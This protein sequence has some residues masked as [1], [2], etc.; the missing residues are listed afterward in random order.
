MT[1]A[2]NDDD[3]D[4]DLNGSQDDETQDAVDLHDE[5]DD[6]GDA[7]NGADDAEQDE[8]GVTVSIDGESPPPE[9]DD[10][11]AP[12]WVKE[13]RKASREKDKLIRELQKKVAE[14]ETPAPTLTLGPKPTL[15]GCEYDPDEFAT[16]LEAWHERKLK[17]DAEQKSR[18]EQQAE[19]E[20]Q[21][22]ARLANHSKLAAELK[23]K[24]F[25]DATAPLESV[26][27]DT[28]RGMIVHAADNSAVLL[29]ALGK[30]PAKAKELASIA[31]PVKFAFAVAKLE[32]KLKVAPRK[33]APIP[34]RTVRGNASVS[35]SVDATLARLE[36]EAEKTGNRTKVV[37][38]KR[39]QKRKQAA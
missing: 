20:R 13:V 2:A 32:T 12:E 19:Q 8:D 5:S 4:L 34:E 30:N 15:E 24:D 7:D 22:K 38:Y 9:E 28:Q 37:A 26:L 29:Y 36:A 23:V 35:G 31:D 25:E 11:S 17:V 16:K 1:V 3:Q 18:Q 21:W 27:T 39:E 14:R 10:N 6:A 33:A